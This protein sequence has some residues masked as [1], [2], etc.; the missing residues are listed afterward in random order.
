MKNLKEKI[1]NLSKKQLIVIF[2][3]L[4]FLF[5]NLFFLE[6]FVNIVITILLVIIL[7]KLANE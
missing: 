6:R 4:L 1:K 3:F 7:L 2:I 5:S